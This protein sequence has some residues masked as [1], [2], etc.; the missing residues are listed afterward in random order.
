MD[1]NRTLESLKE[2]ASEEKRAVRKAEKM[3]VI[4]LQDKIIVG[5]FA[6]PRRGALCK[7]LKE[8]TEE[9]SGGPLA[10]KSAYEELD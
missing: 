5:E 6:N 2:A 10:T 8:L 9:V 7:A 3:D 4:D 1:E